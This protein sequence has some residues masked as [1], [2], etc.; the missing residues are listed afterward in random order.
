M[1]GLS[2]V[3]VSLT[4]REC[5]SEFIFTAGEQQFYQSKGL[6]NQPTRC[7]PCRQL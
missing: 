2:L 4:C 6:V 1:L 3:D 5:G 7:Q